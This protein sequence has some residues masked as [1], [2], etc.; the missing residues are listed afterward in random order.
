MKQL[1]SPQSISALKKLTISLQGLQLAYCHFGDSL[2][3]TAYGTVISAHLLTL[4]PNSVTQILEQAIATANS[5][6]NSADESKHHGHLE[7]TQ[8]LTRATA[9][10]QQ[11]EM[12]LTFLTSKGY[13]RDIALSNNAIGL[14]NDIQTY[15]K[16][17]LEDLQTQMQTNVLHSSNDNTIC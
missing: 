4:P 9:K 17:F 7:L 2:V 5:L 12:F 16:T 10:P 6:A 13:A 11:L 14:T 1:H 3:I 15:L 8:L